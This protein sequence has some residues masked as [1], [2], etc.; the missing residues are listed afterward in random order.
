MES[1]VRF[2]TAKNDEACLAIAILMLRQGKTE[3]AVKRITEALGN[4]SR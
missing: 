1:M 2:N 4:I 3:A